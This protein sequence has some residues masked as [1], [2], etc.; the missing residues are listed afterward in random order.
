MQVFFESRDP[1]TTRAADN[2]AAKAAMTGLSTHTN[3]KES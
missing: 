1:E 2:R 3:P